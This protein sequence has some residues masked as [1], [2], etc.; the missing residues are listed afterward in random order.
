MRHIILLLPS[1]LWIAQAL[2]APVCP[3]GTFY[4]TYSRTSCSL[5]NADI[6]SKYTTASTRG[7]IVSLSTAANSAC[8]LLIAPN[9]S[10][11][12][13]TQ[14][15]VKVNSINLD[16]SSSMSLFSCTSADVC[17]LAYS[18]VSVDTFILHA[19]A[20]MKIVF[21]AG[22]V[23]P[24]TYSSNT[25][26]ISWDS[27]LTLPCL[28]CSNL[29][30]IPT[31]PSNWLYNNGA[32]IGCT[33]EC[34]PGYYIPTT[35]MTADSIGGFVTTGTV[36]CVPCTLC[37]AGTFTNPAK[38]SGGCWGIVT[39]GGTYGAIIRSKN[40]N[41]QQCSSCTPAVTQACSQLSDTVCATSVRSVA[42]PMVGFK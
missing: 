9:I 3:D 39:N 31:T 24:S 15:T 22:P 42:K 2:G 36:G 30:P 18:V 7:E 8:E 25:F 11:G 16:A 17:D 13:A 37:N 21:Q 12:T 23:A 33:W 41:C 14:F 19:T 27:G 26:L 38:Y 32:R 4:A 20:M 1:I 29:V 34:A 28:E 6:E 5:W 35:G 10:L 40:S